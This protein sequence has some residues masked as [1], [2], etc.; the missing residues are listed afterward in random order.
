MNKKKTDYNIDLIGKKLDEPKISILTKLKWIFN[1]INYRYNYKYK[2]SNAY[3]HAKSE[4]DLLC[5]SNTTC[6][7]PIIEEFQKEI[8]TLV[9][10]FGKSGQ[11]GGSA[12]YTAHAISMAIKKLCMFETISPITGNDDEWNV[13]EQE[14]DDIKYQNKRNSAIFKDSNNNAYYL[15]AIIWQGE[16]DFDSFTG[17][18]FGIGSAHYIKS[19]PF[20]PKTFRINLKRELYNPQIHGENV[21]NVISCGSGDY[22]YFIKDEKELDQVWN[23]YNKRN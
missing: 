12:P 18:M 4:L 3:K 22:I 1:D 5:N 11:S 23:Y 7:R 14:R 20:I 13:I 2:H 6:D 9:D 17:Y 21:E 8:L 10:K 16:D 19:F 15:N